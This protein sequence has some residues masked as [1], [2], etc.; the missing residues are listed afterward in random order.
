MWFGWPEGGTCTLIIVII[1]FLIVCFSIRV[2]IWLRAYYLGISIGMTWYG[3][4]VLY[5]CLFILNPQRD[6]TSQA[7]LHWVN[8]FGY[9]FLYVDVRTPESVAYMGEIH[10]TSHVNCGSLES[11]LHAGIVYTCTCMLMVC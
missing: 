8:V 7:P 9:S 2:R 10:F 5:C 3:H 6:I 1:F 11:T 4:K